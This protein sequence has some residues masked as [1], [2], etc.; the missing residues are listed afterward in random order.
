M[1]QTRPF[2]DFNAI[3]ARVRI[4]EVLARY[5]AR[6]NRANQTSLK[7]DC[8]LQQG[9]ARRKLL[10]PAFGARYR[11]RAAGEYRRLDAR[12]SGLN[13]IAIRRRPCS[14]VCVFYNLEVR[15]NHDPRAELRCERHGQTSLPRSCG[16][17]RQSDHSLPGVVLFRS[18][19]YLFGEYT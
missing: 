1:E 8:P 18:E 19:P 15:G 2:L 4:A 14:F 6:L 11:N 9:L 3:K 13:G 12:G 5:H 7:G 10:I 17:R 16:S